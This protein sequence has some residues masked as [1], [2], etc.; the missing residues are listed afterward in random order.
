MEGSLVQADQVFAFGEVTP[1]TRTDLRGFLNDAVAATLDSRLEQF[2]LKS[3]LSVWRRRRD[4][5]CNLK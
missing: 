2:V 3:S 5:Q 1:W 4:C